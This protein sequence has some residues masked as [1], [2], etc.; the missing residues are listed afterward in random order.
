MMH[1]IFTILQC[2]FWCVLYVSS[3]NFF[4]PLPDTDTRFLYIF[5]MQFQ[6]L[7]FF[8]LHSPSPPSSC[9]KIYLFTQNSRWRWARLAC[10]WW[11]GELCVIAR[12]QNIL[13]EFPSLLS[14]SMHHHRRHR[15]QDSQRLTTLY[16]RFTH[17]KLSTHVRIFPAVSDK[18]SLLY[19]FS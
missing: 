15:E 11:I 3:S 7:N 5:C 2:L 18:I 19:T 9:C 13:R 10:S 12:V 6:P 17:K 4:Q 16:L 14:V 1:V 8:S